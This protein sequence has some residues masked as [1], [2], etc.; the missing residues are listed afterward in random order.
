MS[1]QEYLIAKFK[2]DYRDSFDAQGFKLF[3]RSDY[4]AYVKDI[5]QSDFNNLDVYFGMNQYLNFINPE[6]YLKYITI[7]YL[8]LEEFHTIKKAIDFD[9]EYGDWLDITNTASFHI[10]DKILGEIT[11]G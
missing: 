1:K 3:T 6:D 8:S 11:I 10:T 4:D 9:Y 2:R 7:T 5:L